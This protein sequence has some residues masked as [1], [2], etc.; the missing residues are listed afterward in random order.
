MPCQA[1]KNKLVVDEI[2][3]ELKCLETL[4]QILIA[5]RIVFEKNSSYAQRSTKKN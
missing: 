3:S 2:P 5:Q 1:V 4:E